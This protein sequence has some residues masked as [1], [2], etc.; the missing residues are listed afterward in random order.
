[1]AEMWA[2]RAEQ[3]LI[4]REGMENPSRST[5]SGEVWSISPA[6]ITLAPWSEMQQTEAL[7]NET[8]F[9]P[10]SEGYKVAAAFSLP[11]W[12]KCG[13]HLSETVTRRADESVSTA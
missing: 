9:Q 5:H 11:G 7:I 10:E 3:L 1:M 13:A 12:W 6:T 4:L 8:L 2:Q